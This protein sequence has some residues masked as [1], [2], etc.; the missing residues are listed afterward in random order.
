MNPKELS[1]L[2][3]TFL[4]DEIWLLSF[5]GAFGRANVYA[6]G[7]PEKERIGFRKYLRETISTTV[8]GKYKQTVSSESHI[9]ELLQIKGA[10]PET[11]LNILRD[12]TF[13]LGVLQKLMNLYL[14]Y[15]WCLGWIPEPPHC[16]FDRTI[17]E[18]LGVR[19]IDWTKSDSEEEY[20][21]L[22]DAAKKLAGAR[23]I[24]EGELDL[25]NKTRSQARRQ[26]D[27]P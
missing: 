20:N 23:S 3:R 25:F 6:K 16:P 9:Q 13:R 27:N 18:E 26:Y 15:L 24:A 14:K 4:H 22:V 11:Y 10:V 19:G 7:A 5:R 21:Q 2:Q 1:E 17:I 12:R 8:L